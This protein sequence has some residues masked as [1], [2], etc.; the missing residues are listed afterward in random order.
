MG[1][2]A[3]PEEHPDYAWGEESHPE[4][5]NVERGARQALLLRLKL[6]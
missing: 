2:P 6:P 5:G 4:D 3:H 1:W